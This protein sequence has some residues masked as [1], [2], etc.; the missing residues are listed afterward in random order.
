MGVSI[1]S[2]EG[3]GF[4]GKGV[5]APKVR[6]GIKKTLRAT[7]KTFR[8]LGNK[9]LNAADYERTMNLPVGRGRL[10]CDPE[11][12]DFDEDAPRKVYNSKDYPE[13]PLAV[14]S[15]I[16]EGEHY[17]VRDEEEKLKM[18]ATKKWS[19]TPLEKKRRFM[20]T[21]EDQLMNLKGQ[22]EAERAGRLEM[23]RRLDATLSSNNN[24]EAG[25]MLAQQLAEE[26]IKREAL[27]ARLEALMTKLEAKEVPAAN[28]ESED[29]EDKPQVR[30]RR[31]VA[32]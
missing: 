15:T 10:A 8:D 9:A 12:G 17:M 4:V 11:T 2:Y 1:N 14:H 28:L 19:M 25:T 23:E 32:G 18:L 24:P 20:L 5:P 3:P 27:E 29:T 21:P 13:Y 22:V 7:I 31:T 30:G 6:D 26:R 16:T